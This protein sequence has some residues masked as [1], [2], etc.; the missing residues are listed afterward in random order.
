MREEKFKVWDKQFKKWVD[1]TDT[2]LAIKTDGTIVELYKDT[3]MWNDYYTLNYI[4]V[5]YTGRKDKNG[6]EIHEGNIVKVAD[7]SIGIVKY[8][9]EI[10]LG[11]DGDYVSAGIVPG[12]YI[13]TDREDFQS[14]DVSW[15]KCEIIGN[16][17]E[18][19]ELLEGK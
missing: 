14:E 1:G 7:K 19:P 15:Y 18:N 16:I 12:F 4:S 13:S 3:K 5:R 8:S 2:D 11:Y 10:R 9:T 17:Y 6:K